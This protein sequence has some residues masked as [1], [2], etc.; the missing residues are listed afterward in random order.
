[1]STCR[2]NFVGNVEDSQNKLKMVYDHLVSRQP[3]VTLEKAKIIVELFDAGLLNVNYSVPGKK[4]YFSVDF[5]SYNKET[6]EFLIEIIKIFDDRDYLTEIFRYAT[7]NRLLKLA[8]KIVEKPVDLNDDPISLSID[9]RNDE[10]LFTCLRH[11]KIENKHVELAFRKGYIPAM[12]YFLKGR[13]YGVDIDQCL[14]EYFLNLHTDKCFTRNRISEDDAI[15]VLKVRR[16][17]DVTKEFFG[18]YGGFTSLI[19]YAFLLGLEKLIQF[20]ENK[21][22]GMRKVLKETDPSCPEFKRLMDLDF[23]QRSSKFFDIHVHNIQDY[24]R[25]FE[26]Y[27]HINS[28]SSEDL[29]KDP[30]VLI[31]ILRNSIHNLEDIESVACLLFFPLS[32]EKLVDIEFDFDKKEKFV[33][34]IDIL[35]NGEKHRA[36][37]TDKELGKR[38]CELILTELYDHKNFKWASEVL[39]MEIIQVDEDLRLIKNAIQ[40]ED[41]NFFDLVLEYDSPDEGVFRIA[42]KSGWKYAVDKINAHDDY[43]SC[44]YENYYPNHDVSILEHTHALYIM[45]C[46]DPYSLMMAKKDI[47]VIDIHKKFRPSY[48]KKNQFT[49]LE[50]AVIKQKVVLVDAL[51]EFY[52]LTMNDVLNGKYL[53]KKIREIAL[54]N[55]WMFRD[56]DKTKLDE[57][58]FEKYMISRVKRIDDIYDMWLLKGRYRKYVE[59]KKSSI[60]KNVV[61]I[62]YHCPGQKYEM[63]FVDLVKRNLPDGPSHNIMIESLTC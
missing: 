35:F 6:E 18:E 3:F 51:Q 17:F 2:K 32:R 8:A 53:S 16:D 7:H 21:G 42:Y 38:L 22:H 29:I 27:R 58:Q 28:F 37:F 45:S 57:L 50:Y 44:E 15:A 40:F 63:E 26:H 52:N 39:R 55:T 49:L 46:Y 19:D 30:R 13:C 4:S 25:M 1:M 20:F 36:N 62:G 9:F 48:E 56:I 31:R 47:C 14:V 60:W 11:R 59:D 34:G 54:A 23:E 5:F 43:G 41:E 33:R 12:K 61:E 10:F 24:S